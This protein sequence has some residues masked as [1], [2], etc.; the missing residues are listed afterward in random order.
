MQVAIDIVKGH[1]H[2][3][4]EEQ[5]AMRKR[6]PHL[7]GNTSHLRYDEAISTLNTI[8]EELEAASNPAPIPVN[9]W[10]TIKVGDTI[11]D[12]RNQYTVTAVEQTQHLHS[13]RL[14][15]GHHIHQGEVA[16]LALAP[17]HFE[18]RY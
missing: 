1:A 3:L 2:R 18:L 4:V 10:D 9:E 16:L 6:N 17:N 13:I 12:G 7:T 5:E 11:R 8:L 14:D 15:Q